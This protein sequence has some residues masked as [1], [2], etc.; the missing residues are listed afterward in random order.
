MSAHLAVEPASDT[1]EN[2]AEPGPHSRASHAARWLTSLE[3]LTVIL[4]TLLAIAL[5]IRLATNVGGL[6]RDE[7]NS[8]NLSTLRSFGEIWRYLDYDSFPVLFF[9]VLRA[10]TAVFGADNDFA[11]RALGLLTGLSVLGA[12]W[13]N[14]RSL[15]ARVPVLSLALAGLNP[16]VI[17][18]GDSTRAYGLGIPLILLTFH[19]FWRLVHSDSPPSARRISLATVLALLSVHSL[20][21]NSVLLFAIACGA[22]AVAARKRAWRTITIVLGIGILSAASLLPY[23]P[24]MKRMRAWTFMVSYP[25]DFA[26]LW[27]RVGEVIGSPDPITVWLWVILFLLGVGMVATSLSL[28]SLRKS[29]PDAMLFT[30]VGL[31]IGVAG[32]AAFLRVLNYYT[33]PWYYITLAVF[34]AC[35]LDV[36]FGAWPPI[37][38][39]AVGSHCLRI[40]AAISLLSLTGLPAWEEMPTRHTNVDL[41]SNKLQALATKGDVILVP[42]WECGITLSRYYHGPAEVIT[43]PPITDHRFHRYDLILNE[44]MTPDALK[45]TIARFE[46]ALRSGHRVFVAGVLPFPSSD[47]SPPI[48]PPAYRDAEGRFHGS[49][50][51]DRAWH[52]QAGHFLRSHATHGAPLEVPVPGG[53]PVQGFEKLDLFVLEGWR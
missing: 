48:L 23:I 39:F 35:A 52:L 28:R 51:Y 8:V 26:W 4:V 42:R 53:A 21:Y 43:I 9:A 18:Y 14:A 19:S 41:L 17:R 47:F 33:Q 2:L 38:R 36:L 46:E 22:I 45:T 37:T 15:G 27:K 13:L 6:W 16:M 29:V 32:Y 25:A 1:T 7:A 49:G 3:W 34:A 11:L 5:H 31:V 24:M 30:V 10:W 12:L 20:Y 40:A 44:M 50:S